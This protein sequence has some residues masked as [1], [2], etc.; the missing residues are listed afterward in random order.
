[1]NAIAD[2]EYFIHI[3]PAVV[4]VMRGIPTEN[5]HGNVRDVAW[6]DSDE[7]GNDVAL[8]HAYA[9]LSLFQKQGKN[10][11]WPS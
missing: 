10:V 1:M 5:G 6:F 11:R 8:N 7:L 2:Y 4:I 9:V 3:D